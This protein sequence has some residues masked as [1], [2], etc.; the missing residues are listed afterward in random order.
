MMHPVPTASDPLPTE[1]VL[2]ALLVC[3]LVGST[4][5]TARL[6][7]ARAADIF[8]KHDNAARSL[9]KSHNGI[10]IDKTDGFLLLFERPVNAVLF[11]LAYHEALKTL[12]DSEGIDLQTRVAI[13]LGEVVLRDNDREQVARGAK[14]VEV[15]GLAKPTAARVMAIALGRQTLLTRAAFDLARRAL[16]GG[17]LQGR[18]LKWLAHGSYLFKGVDEPL[19]VF[20]VGA[21]GLAPLT[22]PGGGEK[23]Q[24]I[25]G[26]GT[27][28]GWRPAPSLEVPQ[29]PNWLVERK[30]GEGGF[31]EVWLATHQKTRDKRVFKFCYD[32]KS[33]HSLKR[34]TTL[35]RLLKGELGD[36][37]DIAR[38]LDWN[39]DE[40]P[41]FIESEYTEGGSFLDWTTQR[42]GLPSVPL[43]TR[44]EIIAQIAESLAAAHSVGVLHKDVKPAN[45]LIAQDRDGKPRVLLTDF[46]IGRITD[47]ERLKAAGITKLGMTEMAPVLDKSYETGGTRLYLAPELVEGKAA[48]VQ[49]DIYAL[50]V[51]LYQVIVGDFSRSL[52]PGWQRDVD[53]EL[54]REDIA[55]AVDGSASRRL[56][57]ANRLAERLRALELR[58]AELTRKRRDEE[59]ARQAKFALQAAKRRRRVMLGTIAVLAVFGGSMSILAQRIAS[60]RDRANREAETA[61]QVAAFL[62]D[63]FEVSDPSEA[64]GNTITAR[65]IL[66]RGSERIGAELAR[67]P[68]VQARLMDTIGTVYQ[69]LGLYDQS[70]EL[71]RRALATRE[72]LFG[73]AD[74]S[75]AESKAHLARVLSLKADYDSAETLHREA[76]DLRR[77]QLEPDDPVIADSLAGLADTLSRMGDYEEAGELLTEALAIRRDKLGPQHLDIAQTLE[78]MGLNLYDQGDYDAALPLLRESL[79]MR[80]GLVG[81]APDPD[82]AEVVNNLAL[83]L[84]AQ[85]DYEAAETHYREALA[86][87]N[88]LYEGEHPEIAT[89][90]NN[91]A[92]VLHDNGK[93]EAAEAAYREVIEMQE[94]LL[95]AEHPD[96]A[97][98]LNNLSFLLWDKG[99]SEAAI[100]MSR[101]SLDM[102]RRTV[103]ESH[104]MVA[105]GLSNL[106]GFLLQNGDDEAAE[107]LLREGLLM[108][109]ELLGATH[110]DVAK[111]Q[112]V[113]AELLVNAHQ[114][115]EALELSEQAIANFSA[116]LSPGHWRT[117]IASGIKGASLAGLGRY[118]TAEP[119]LLSCYSTVAADKR[120]RTPYQVTALNHLIELYKAWGRPNDAQ[121]YIAALEKLRSKQMPH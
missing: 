45:V 92:F 89:G 46:G 56:G 2:R 52:A 102:Y 26:D 66:E 34:E 48:T 82:V 63:I 42:G 29:R 90:L 31:G 109:L 111:S 71:L 21:D 51:M 75:V 22:A 119:L 91:L 110:P 116:S 61:T 36:R 8:A 62:T 15:E 80:I 59:E 47:A 107:P 4:R 32:A 28:P 65:E 12:S 44:L 85:G 79:Q 70:V 40:A 81:D 112:T 86:M 19:E 6:G 60:E 14:P 88:A 120:I 18:A 95:G 100:A 33:L 27:I 78:D 118:D 38:I 16:V 3:D 17:D 1:A 58:T 76:L 50:G 115:Q 39:F 103:G 10:E 73:S 108:R 93:Y 96:V 11:A 49:A 67:Q 30:L 55:A 43:Q 83:L 113:L 106:G 74:L 117:A 68:G 87:K 98:A 37:D 20:E 105:R 94:E 25:I 97:L 24:R 99:K 54:L 101:R 72:G 5:L 9:L 57:N 121:I 53:D 69:G 114:Y 84:H 35:F 41:Y 104:P 23:A 7:D 77:A 64:R 13:H